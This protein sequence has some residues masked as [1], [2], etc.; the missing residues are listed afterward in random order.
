MVI[1]CMTND[2][3][4]APGGQSVEGVGVAYCEVVIDI[5]V[6]CAERHNAIT[7]NRKTYRT[8]TGVYLQF[9]AVSFAN[10]VCDCFR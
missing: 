7:S 10:L 5:A 1:S 3:V 8:V 9:D 4:H 6:V 2:V